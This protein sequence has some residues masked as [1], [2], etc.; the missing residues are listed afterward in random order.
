[1]QLQLLLPT[2]MVP[3]QVQMFLEISQVVIFP[4]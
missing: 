1:M 3:P 2:Q 4:D